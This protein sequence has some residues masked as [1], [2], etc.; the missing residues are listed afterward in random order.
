[1]SCMSCSAR[2]GIIQCYDCNSFTCDK[3]SKI[4]CESCANK[5]DPS[6]CG[7]CVRECS[8]CEKDICGNCEYMC[9]ICCESPSC[10][11]CTVH[12]THCI[13]CDEEGLSSDLNACNSCAPHVE[14]KE[15]MCEDCNVLSDHFLS[16]GDNELVAEYEDMCLP[17]VRYHLILKTCFNVLKK[18]ATSSRLTPGHAGYKRHLQDVIARGGFA[19]RSARLACHS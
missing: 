1:M 5:G 6:G 15:I 4:Y 18:F 7:Y 8:S 14:S 11:D 19:R 16:N 3:C 9:D 12:F 13:A 17:E 2:T 10:V